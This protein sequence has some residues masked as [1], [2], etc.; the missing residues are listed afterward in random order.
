M[1]YTGYNE[2]ELKELILILEKHQV[3]F[4]VSSNDEAIEYAHAVMKGR[5]YHRDKTVGKIPNGF[6]NV[7]IA[8]G[9]LK[10]LS[11]QALKE[12]E[13]MRVFPEMEMLPE[14]PRP[15]QKFIID[16]KRGSQDAVGMGLSSLVVLIVAM[17]LWYF[18]IQK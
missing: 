15:E 14:E 13:A 7:E 6:Y 9:E 4:Q 10:K 3:P 5:D 11:P 17:I 2:D 18:F 8:E 16:E 1:I 12:L